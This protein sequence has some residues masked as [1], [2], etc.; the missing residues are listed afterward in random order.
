[1]LLAAVALP[2]ADAGAARALLQAPVGP[3]WVPTEPRPSGAVGQGGTADPR[4]HPVFCPCRA[5]RQRLLAAPQ[6]CA[7]RG[8]RGQARA[9]PGKGAEPSL[10]LPCHRSLQLTEDRSRV[11]EHLRQALPYLQS[12]REPLREAATRFMGEPGLPPCPATARPQPRLLPRQ[13]HPG[14][15]PR[16]PGCP[17]GC[18]HPL[19]AVP[20]GISMRQGPGLSPAG[21][22]GR[23][24]TGL[25]GSCA[26]GAVTGSVF[27]GMAK[28]LMREHK[29][30]LQ[31]LSEGE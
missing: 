15:A 13:R 18:C 6:G 3:S 23:V 8:G 24:A 16:S 29:E 17:R 5:W 1:M 22:G 4:A 31:L 12:P 28:A 25:A 2:R 14:P 10:T 27:P 21:P 26:T 30:D 20:L 19:A 9:A 7:G 11:D